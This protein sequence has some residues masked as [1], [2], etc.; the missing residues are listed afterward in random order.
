[1]VDLF[2]LLGLFLLRP[3]VHHLYSMTTSGV[4]G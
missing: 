4:S 2:C 3:E 1:V